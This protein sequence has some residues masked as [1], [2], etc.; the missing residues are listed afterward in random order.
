MRMYV[1][2]LLK[3]CAE[4]LY[5]VYE[6]G[7]PRTFNLEAYLSLANECIVLSQMPS[8]DQLIQDALVREALSDLNEARGSVNDYI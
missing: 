7:D 2:K 8:N 6:N 4:Y 3:L 1:R 5:Y